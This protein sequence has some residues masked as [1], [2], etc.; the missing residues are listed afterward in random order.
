M[1]SRTRGH[2]QRMVVTN[3]DDSADGLGSESDL[4]DCRLLARKEERC[5]V[6]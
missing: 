5:V 1:K 2:Q 4:T 3:P 6:S